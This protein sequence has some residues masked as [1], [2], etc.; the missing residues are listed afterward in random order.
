MMKL[1]HLP[2]LKTNA[3]AFKKRTNTD[4]HSFKLSKMVSHFIEKADIVGEDESDES[5]YDYEKSDDSDNE[6][7]EAPVKKKVHVKKLQR[8]DDKAELDAIKGVK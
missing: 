5:N 3:L 7:M 8:R 4:L 6:Q 1:L 2:H